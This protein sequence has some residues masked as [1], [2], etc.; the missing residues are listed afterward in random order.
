MLRCAYL[1]HRNLG[2]WHD[3]AFSTIAW[4]GF[5]YGLVYFCWM[6]VNHRLCGLWPYPFCDKLFATKS[7][8]AAFVAGVACAMAAVSYVYYTISVALMPMS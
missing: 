5:V 3:Q 2:C 8:Q 6:H 1:T 7:M 4:V